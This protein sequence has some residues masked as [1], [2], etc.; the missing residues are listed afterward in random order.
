MVADGNIELAVQRYIKGLQYLA[1]VYDL[2]PQDEEEIKTLKL[3]LQLNLSQAYLKLAGTDL[4]APTC[5]PFAK[6]AIAS[7]DAALEI[8]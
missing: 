6:K 1:K 4:K 5:E 8:E 3:S 2:S 7:C